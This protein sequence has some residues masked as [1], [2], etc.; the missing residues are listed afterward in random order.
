ML[1]NNIALYSA[2]IIVET[3]KEIIFFPIWWYSIG[4]AKVVRGLMNFLS[5]RQRSLALFVWIKNIFKPMYQ[6]YDWQGLLISFFMR[7]IMIVIRG[8]AL[9][10]WVVFALIALAFWLALPLYVI[11]QIVFQ[12]ELIKF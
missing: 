3:I 5:D 7:S 8:V 4:L 9:L 10:F 6:Q 12:L 11:Y 1:T 2:K